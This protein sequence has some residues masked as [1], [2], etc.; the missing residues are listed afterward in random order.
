MTNSTEHSAAPV[1]DEHRWSDLDPL[2]KFGVALAGIL[3]CL[4]VLEGVL[5]VPYALIGHG[6]TPG[7]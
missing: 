6:W 4:V 7:H 1:D 3:F 5:L 2:V